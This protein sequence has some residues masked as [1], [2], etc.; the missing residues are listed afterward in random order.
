[1][2]KDWIAK[3]AKE[4]KGSVKESIAEAIGHAKQK[5]NVS[6]FEQAVPL[7]GGIRAFVALAARYVGAKNNKR[8]R[9]NRRR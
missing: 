1:M 7:Y 5:A 2:D 8:K 4:I 3:A 9:E 6:N